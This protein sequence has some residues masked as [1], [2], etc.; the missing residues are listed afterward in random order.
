MPTSKQGRAMR[1]STEVA[2]TPSTKIGVRFHVMPCARIVV[3]VTIRFT[4]PIPDEITNMMIPTA[5]ASMP[6]GA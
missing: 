2:V 1:P 5:K 4:A 6:G 3:A